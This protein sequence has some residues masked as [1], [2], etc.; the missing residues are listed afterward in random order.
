MVTSATAIR[1]RNTAETAIKSHVIRPIEELEF[2]NESA[3]NFKNSLI[4]AARYVPT[5][6]AG[7]NNGHTYLL[8]SQ[9]EHHTRT[10]TN[11]DYKETK[12][13]PAINFNGASKA[14]DVAQQR[15]D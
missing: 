2:T 15:E 10:N 12:R 4:A 6:I 11:K 9:E 14:A 1:I 3:R 8:E 5:M 13:P 7:G